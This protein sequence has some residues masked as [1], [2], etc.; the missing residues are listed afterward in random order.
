[1]KAKLL[2]F[3]LPLL[4][5]LGLG[6]D[7]KPSQT[8]YQKKEGLH[9]NQRGLIVGGGRTRN[10]EQGENPIFTPGIKTSHFRPMNGRQFYLPAANMY[11]R[12]KNKVITRKAIKINRNNICPCGAK[13]DKQYL[14]SMGVQTIP[15]PKKYKNCCINKQLFFSAANAP[16]NA[17]YLKS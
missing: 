12:G 1:M 7:F 17:N 4:A 5:L 10:W 9:K 2:N 6:S 16:Q 15:T 11:E 8:D 14:T 13:E 3:F